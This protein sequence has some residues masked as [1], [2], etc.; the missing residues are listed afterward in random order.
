MWVKV[1][2]FRAVHANTPATLHPDPSWA[3]AG[4][5]TRSRA[6]SERDLPRA[7]FPPLQKTPR[8]KPRVLAPLLQIRADKRRSILVLHVSWQRRQRDAHPDAFQ[9]F[10]ARSPSQ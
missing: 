4:A 7:T 10:A 9:T 3:V 6:F 5:T 8:V 2:M 1:Q